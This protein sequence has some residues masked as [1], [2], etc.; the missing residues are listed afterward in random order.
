[1][2]VEQHDRAVAVDR[3]RV[4]VR[5]V[6]QELGVTPGTPEYLRLLEAAHNEFSIDEFG[7]KRPPLD[8][9]RAAHESLKGASSKPAGLKGAGERMPTNLK[10]S[11]RLFRAAIGRM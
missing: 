10:E 3:A 6:A 11:A 2:R 8:A 7:K 4:N 9:I 5:G 1:M